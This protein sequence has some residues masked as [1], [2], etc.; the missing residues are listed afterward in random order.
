MKKLLLGVIAIFIYAIS[1]SQTYTFTGNGL[2]TAAANWNNSTIPPATLPSGDTIVINP[3]AGDSCVL[4]VSQTISAGAY[5][6]VATGANFVV[7]GGLTI[8]NSTNANDSIYIDKIYAVS[9]SGADTGVI[10]TYNYDN[11]K[12]VTSMIID[13]P[14]NN[15]NVKYFYYYNNSDILP[16]KSII[17]RTFEDG[18]GGFTTDSIITFHF[19]NSSGKNIKDSV[20]RSY[21]TIYTYSYNS[22]MIY[23]ASQSTISGV[24]MPYRI[25]TAT[26]D[27]NGDIVSSKRYFYINS[28]SGGE[29]ELSSI[30]NFTYDNHRSPFAILSNFKT[31]G[32]FPSGETL[33]FELPHN[34]V[35]SSQHETN[36]L[37][38]F[39]NDYSYDWINSYTTD[40]RLKEVLGVNPNDPLD[41]GKWIFTYKA[42]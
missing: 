36:S 3:G 26:L 41:T 32:V 16:F 22:N 15:E 25:D 13:Y 11:L 31:F 23:G 5:L 38:T 24:V 6:I 20:I 34:N 21:Y 17:Y 37:S 29:W 28:S 9:I 30:S 2:W 40:G 39:P 4:N 35:P 8:N 19:Y 10:W 18:S 14:Y 7:R 12:R 42:L 33:Y 1:F 27:T